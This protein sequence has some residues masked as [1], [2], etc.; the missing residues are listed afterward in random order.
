MRI[1][2]SRIHRLYMT[3]EEFEIFYEYTKEI[4]Y[5]YMYDNFAID[6]EPWLITLY[7]NMLED[8]YD[9]LEHAMSYQLYEE[10]NSA[11]ASEI[12]DL[13]DEIYTELR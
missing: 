11:K 2:E 13:M 10:C 8:C 6:D 5:G 3:D 12:R 1:S 4:G 7:D 9:L